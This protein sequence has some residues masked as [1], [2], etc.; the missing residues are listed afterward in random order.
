[1]ADAST[2]STTSATKSAVAGKKAETDASDI[3]SQ[4]RA[5][6][7]DVSELTKLIGEYGQAQKTHYTG[8]AR[9]KAEQFKSDAEAQY[10][11]A[12]AQ[13]RDAYATAEERI[14]EN[15][16]AAVA[17]ASG[18]GFLIGLFMSRR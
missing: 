5:L 14:R 15:P 16:A 2:T 6:Q 4:L 17:I 12:E 18:F 7:K 9:A 13:A 11:K 3:Q 8:A 1:M 10:L